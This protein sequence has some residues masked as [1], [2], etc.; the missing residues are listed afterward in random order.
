MRIRVGD[1]VEII[2]GNDSGQRGKVMKIVS[3]HGKVVVEGMNRA[4]KHLKRSQKNPQG[5]RLS[6]EMPLQASNVMLVCS[7]CS[8]A[9]RVGVR[10]AADGS[11]QRF[12]KKCNASIS[13]LSPAKKRTSGAK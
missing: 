10:I 13:R 7:A 6:K 12:C 5:G 4:F 11:K 1:T 2:S 3:K 9:S 8:Q